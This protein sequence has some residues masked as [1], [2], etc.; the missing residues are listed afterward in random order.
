MLYKKD[1][2]EAKNHFNIAKAYENY[3][4]RDRLQDSIKVY[5]KKIK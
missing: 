5:M 1:F 4:S 3:F 2:E